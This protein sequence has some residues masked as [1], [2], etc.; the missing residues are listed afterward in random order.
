VSNN[1]GIQTIQITGNDH[2]FGEVNFDPTNSIGRGELGVVYRG[3]ARRLDNTTQDVVIKIPHTAEKSREVETEFNILTRINHILPEKG[4]AAVPVVAIG[5]VEGSPGPVLV[6]PYYEDRSL[7]IRQVRGA[8]FQDDVLLAEQIAVHSGIQYCRIM[9]ALRQLVPAQTSTDRKIKDFYVLDNNQT[10]II[11]WNVLRDDLPEY[12]LT[13]LRLFGYLWH[14]LFLERKGQPPFEPYTDLR[15][16]AVW[17]AQN[18]Q[19]WRS[20]GLMSVGLRLILARTVAY[21][22]SMQGTADFE[23]LARILEQWLALITADAPPQSMGTIE[24]LFQQFPDHQPEALHEAEAEAIFQDLRWRLSGTET[25]LRDE[26]VQRARQSTS[27]GIQLAHKIIQMVESDPRT[28]IAE[29]DSLNQQAAVRSEWIDWSHIQRWQHLLALWQMAADELNAPSPSIRA[30]DLQDIE[31]RLFLA[32]E[33]LHTLPADD[34]PDQ[35]D[36]VTHALDEVLEFFAVLNNEDHAMVRAEVDVRRLA[37][38]FTRELTTADMINRLKDMQSILNRSGTPHYLSRAPIQDG[39]YENTLLT[40]IVHYNIFEEMVHAIATLNDLPSREAYEQA[41]RLA[42]ATAA[43][44]GEARWMERRLRPITALAQFLLSYGGG[45]WDVKSLIQQPAP[46]L[47]TDTTL[48]AR[49]VLVQ[50]VDHLIQ[51]SLYLSSEATTL[52]K[53]IDDWKILVGDALSTNLQAVNVL[54]Q[55]IVREAR[56]EWHHIAQLA[57]IVRSLTAHKAELSEMYQIQVDDK[58]YLAFNDRRN[59]YQE[60]LTAVRQLRQSANTDHLRHLLSLFAKAD[61][62]GVDMTDLLGIDL[63]QKYR[64]QL[65][66]VINSELQKQI[67]VFVNQAQQ[68]SAR[69]SESQTQIIT[70][71]DHL[72]ENMNEYFESIKSLK[73][74]ASAELATLQRHQLELEARKALDSLDPEQVYGF[75]NQLPLLKSDYDALVVLQRSTTLLNCLNQMSNYMPTSGFSATSVTGRL[76]EIR[77]LLRQ[78]KINEFNDPRV[79]SSFF[80]EKDILKIA[81]GNSILKDILDLYWVARLQAMRHSDLDSLSVN[82]MDKSIEEMRNAQEQL[83]KLQQL[84]DENELKQARNVL[85]Q[86]RKPVHNLT[87]SIMSQLV[88]AWEERIVTLEAYSQQMTKTTAK[89]SAIRDDDKNMLPY[90]YRVLQDELLRTIQNCPASAYNRSLHEKLLEALRLSDSKLTSFAA[91]ASTGRHSKEILPKIDELRQIIQKLTQQAEQ[92]YKQYKRIFRN[93]LTEGMR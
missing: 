30:R 80:I 92:Q 61:Q 43:L 18:E 2:P 91:A 23:A 39:D 7:L 14:E 62:L 48:P 90:L 3:L 44:D 28:A 49:S 52:D 22:S 19:T 15:W 63:I 79:E 6:M 89:L 36:E 59:F 33:R 76:R 54:I 87:D 17:V 74:K 11:D 29:L 84:F 10:V 41:Y 71:A 50:E 21:S 93:T 67:E 32:G 60:T 75:I 86:I 5:S 57:F 4:K 68:M 25:D 78:G 53:V 42:I 12:R 51:S 13:E 70:Q 26:A 69:F 81:Q 38:T 47:P 64:D 65:N 35:L 8:L 46:R 77:D 37:M 24:R 34:S 40:Q 56:P 9:L 31:R 66:A 82:I 72:R 55:G 88:V 27:K 83:A 45:A 73:D 1:S 85:D 16:R 20:R 58:L